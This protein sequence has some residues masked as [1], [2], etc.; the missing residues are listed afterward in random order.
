MHSPHVLPAPSGS[1]HDLLLRQQQP[2]PQLAGGGMYRPMLASSGPLPTQQQQQQQQQPHHSVPVPAQLAPPGALVPQGPGMA[3]LNSLLDAIR[4]EFENVGQDLVG[5]YKHD[6]DEL[7]QRLSGQITE[8]TALQQNLYDLERGY[9]KIKQTYEEEIH[10]LRRDL[11]ARGNA[12]LPPDARPAPRPAPGFPEG[13]PPILGNPKGLAAGGAF[14]AFM[15]SSGGHGPGLNGSAGAVGDSRILHQVTDGQGNKRMRTEDG[16]QTLGNRD[17]MGPPNPYMPRGDPMGREQPPS[18]YQPPPPL[19]RDPAK[20]HR[21]NINASEDPYNRQSGKDQLQSAPAYNGP[22]NPYGNVPNSQGGLGMG[23]LALPPMQMHGP[24]RSGT[25]THG[26]PQ[27][28]QQQGPPPPQ[29]PQPPPPSSQQAIHMHQFMQHAY[30][31]HEIT[32]ICDLDQDTAPP[33]FVK[34]GADWV[35]VYNQQS[36]SLQKSRVSVDLVHSLEHGSVVCCVKFSPDGKLLATGCNKNAHVYDAFSGVKISTLMDESAPTDIDLYI[37]SVC[38]SPDNQLLATGAEDR[39]IRVWN[40]ARRQIVFSLMGHDQ[41]IYSLD[42]SRDGRVIVSGSG[43]RT[44]RVWDAENGK[45]S[46]MMKNDDS[47]MN[48]SPINGSALKDSGVTSVAVSPT[49][50]RCVATGSLDEMVRVW[51]IRTG[52]LLER[53]EGHK[54]SVYSVAFSPDGQSIVS[55]SLDKTLKI[56]DLSPA[57]LAYVNQPHTGE[58]LRFETIV[59]SVPRHTFVGHQDYV[60]SVAFAGRGS[61]I[62]RV[63][64]HGSPVNW[65]A[66]EALAE[67]E[68][69]VSGSKD[70]SVTF[71]D[72]RAIM[73]G[74]GAGGAGAANGGSGGSAAAKPSASS[75]SASGGTASSS[76]AVSQ[77]MLHGHKNSVISVALGSAGGMFATGSGDCKAR[78]WRVSAVPMPLLPP[79]NAAPPPSSHQQQQGPPLSATQQQQQQQQHQHHQ[80]TVL[81]SMRTERREED[82]GERE[83]ERGGEKGE[84]NNSNNMDM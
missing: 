81:P 55:G 25:P 24:P 79:M 32:G 64:E 84:P 29:Q 68:W 4:G 57:T 54:N 21:K 76:S 28:Q 70:R 69:L 36:P 11:D 12:A 37:R 74:G 38:F 45:L 6:R 13:P 17:M 47:S 75:S 56:W 8:L 15:G 7:E 39:V 20:K 31:H 44:V 71:W 60:L 51:D 22:N 2:P 63:D 41:D 40:I 67:V 59:S 48:S 52:Q 50:G 10:R 46:K 66:T 27:Q 83:R 23:G 30:P 53:F 43:D 49:D 34:E 58:E 19:D 61:S 82:R 78:I 73:G 3:R 62:G 9:Q 80:H 42:W 5:G 18:S 72:G 26:P 65:P 33:G 14:S 35:V 16:P 1:T 77:F